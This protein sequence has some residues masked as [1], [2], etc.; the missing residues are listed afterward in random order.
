MGLHSRNE[1][2]YRHVSK[3]C[4]ESTFYF[5][6]LINFGFLPCSTIVVILNHLCR[7]YQILS[8]FYIPKKGSS[9]LWH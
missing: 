2:G 9:F 5:V 8:G 3:Q 6:S 4:D 1:K 7:A